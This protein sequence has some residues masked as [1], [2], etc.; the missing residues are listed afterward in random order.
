MC[1]C[2]T[3]ACSQPIATNRLVRSSYFRICYLGEGL[4]YTWDSHLTIYSGHVTLSYTSHTISS[5]K[6]SMATAL[7]VG[8]L[9][10][11]SRLD[12]P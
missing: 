1:A 6:I 11:Q 4:R 3:N 9:S 10:V 7:G 8:G 2:A 12:G 5:P